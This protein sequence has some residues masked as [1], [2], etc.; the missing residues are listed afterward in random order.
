M[1]PL[2]MLLAPI[3]NGLPQIISTMH[4]HLTTP[5]NNRLALLPPK[6]III[7][8]IPNK[9]QTQAGIIAQNNVIINDSMFLLM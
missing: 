3:K 2:Y 1:M 7:H 8:I 9:T 4:A 5:V 6:V